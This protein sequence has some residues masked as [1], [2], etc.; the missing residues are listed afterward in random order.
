MKSIATI[1]GVLSC[2]AIFAACASADPISAGSLALV[3]D[4]AGVDAAE[5]AAPPPKP[6]SCVLDPKAVRFW[7]S[8]GDHNPYL[9]NHCSNTCNSGTCTLYMQADNGVFH[10]VDGVC[11][12]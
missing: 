10:W 5:A 4:D 12:P 3:V 2:G 6:C 7:V 9:V 8:L 1:G 11:A